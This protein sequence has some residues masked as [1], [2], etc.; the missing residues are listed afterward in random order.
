MLLLKIWLVDICARV[1]LDLKH[2]LMYDL[3][4]FKYSVKLL[5]T[6]LNMLIETYL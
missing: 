2:V 6:L 1:I 4:K 5:K 3:N